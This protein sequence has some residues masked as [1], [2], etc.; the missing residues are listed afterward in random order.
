MQLRLKRILYGTLTISLAIA[1]FIVSSQPAHATQGEFSL[2]VTPSP[3]VETLTPGQVK[4]VDLRIRN[5]GSTTEHLKITPRSFSVNS[6]DGQLS[7]NDTVEPEIASWLEFSSKDFVVKPG[8]W[9]TEKL[10]FSVPKDAGFSYSFALVIDRQKEIKNSDEGVQQLRGSVAIFGLINI[11]R[12]GATRKLDLVTFKSSQAFYEYMPV[13]FNVEVKNPGNTIVQ[14]VGNIFIQRSAADKQPISTMPVNPTKGYVLPGATRVFST[15]WDD[16]FQVLVPENPGD[17]ASKKNVSWN[18]SNV[19]HL[20]IGK[21]TARVVV[22]YNDGQRDIPTIGEVSFWI[23]PWKLI[24]GFLIVI[25][26]VGVGLWSL[27]RSVIRV[28]SRQKNKMRRL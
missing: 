9:Y 27:I 17:A 14:P 19:S 21:Y 8:E 28:F 5:T 23:I 4:T 10:T 22:V 18:W 7:L 12:P 2:Q 1:G 15:G 13:T 11:D 25:S 6:V 16:G 24:G 20:R 26:L 3:I